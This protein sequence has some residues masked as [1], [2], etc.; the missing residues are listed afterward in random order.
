MELDQILPILLLHSL[1]FDCVNA[2]VVNNIAFVIAIVYWL[3][4]VGNDLL[5][6]VLC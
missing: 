2:I 1:V 3:E 4:N 5:V 6:V